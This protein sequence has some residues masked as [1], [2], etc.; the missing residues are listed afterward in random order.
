M[1]VITKI[2]GIK[3]MQSKSS[4]LIPFLLLVFQRKQKFLRGAT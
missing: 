3:K 1:K 2:T 4:D